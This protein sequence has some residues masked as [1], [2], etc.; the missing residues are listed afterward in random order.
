MAKQITETFDLSLESMT[1]MVYCALALLEDAGVRGKN[2]LKSG[3][4]KVATLLILK[5][6]RKHNRWAY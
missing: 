6:P 4:A 3:K 2:G 1:L 5:C